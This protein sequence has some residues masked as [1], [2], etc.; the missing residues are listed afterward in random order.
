MV[1]KTLPRKLSLDQLIA[2]AAVAISAV[3]LVAFGSQIVDILR[4]REAVADAERRVTTQ[5]AEKAALQKQ[6]GENVYRLVMPALRK[7]KHGG[8]QPHQRLIKVLENTLREL[9]SKFGSRIGADAL[10]L[11]PRQVELCNMIRAGMS[12]KDIA[13]TLGISV[14]TVETHRNTIRKKL[15][16]SAKDVSLVSCLQS[17]AE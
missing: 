1:K 15:G 7:L 5:Q 10:G 9:T 17:L 6:V 3:F 12:S 13:A 4:W 2:V 8:N 16:I 11:T 14:R